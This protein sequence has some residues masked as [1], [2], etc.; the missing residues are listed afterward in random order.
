MNLRR[1]SGLTAGGCST[2]SAA[3]IFRARHS[4]PSSD[5]CF[6]S[7]RQ[8]PEDSDRLADPRKELSAVHQ[9]AIDAVLDLPISDPRWSEL[10]P[11]ARGRAISEAS[12]AIL[13]GVARHSGTVLLIEDLHWVDRASDT[14]IAAIASLQV[15]N[16]FVF[17][18]SR[19][20]GMP[21]WIARCHAEV[22]AMRPLDD[23]FGMAMLADMLGTSVTNAGLKNRIIS[24][25]ANVPLFIEEVCRGLKDNGTLRGQWGDLALV[26]PIEELG[27]PTSI[28]GVIAARLDRVS[29]QERLVLQIAA[30]L[31]PR[32]SEAVVRRV[33]ELPED[34]LRDCLAALDRAELLVRIDSDIGGLARVSARDGSP[35]DLRV[36]GRK[37]RAR[38]YMRAFLRH[39]R[40]TKY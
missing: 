4:A 18:T 24:H 8:S 40:A 21:E 14:V 15:P 13:E 30:A 11:Y 12:C 26:R 20:N 16:L 6:P 33:A 3:Q 34:A 27:I 17:L 1:A 36:D 38:A 9:F 28:Q 31:G 23:E 19:P 7:W 39:S 2:P 35:G 29:R 22:I 32:S 5:W 37:G 10:E 25:T